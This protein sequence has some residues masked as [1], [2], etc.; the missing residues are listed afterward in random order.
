MKITVVLQI[1]FYKQT[2]VRM[3]AQVGILANENNTF[4]PQICRKLL[5]QQY[6]KKNFETILQQHNF[7]SKFCYFSNAYMSVNFYRIEMFFFI[8]WVINCTL[9]KKSMQNESN[10][11]SPLHGLINVWCIT[12]IASF[13]FSKITPKLTFQQA[14]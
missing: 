13:F 3:S 4:F 9:R 12:W 6:R 1:T 5:Y 7:S 11:I 10:S 14:I 2:I 8:L